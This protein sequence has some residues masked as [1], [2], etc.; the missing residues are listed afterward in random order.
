MNKNDYIENL[1][2]ISEQKYV[3][4]NKENDPDEEFGIPHRV[5]VFMESFYKTLNYEE[6][7]NQKK[8]LQMETALGV[9][10]LL[11]PGERQ[12]YVVGP[13]LTEKISLADFFSNL[14][15][16]NL[17]IEYEINMFYQSLSVFPE[18]KKEAL[19]KL[20]ELGI[21]I[22]CYEEIKQKQCIPIQMLLS[23]VRSTTRTSRTVFVLNMRSVNS[24]QHVSFPV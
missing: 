3:I 5:Y 23:S 16:N 18:E 19:K 2:M 22:D 1:L 17:P 7:L 6:V 13:Y 4:W 15:N 10:N 20:L 24:R 8:L 9:C 12:I 14:I 21:G 11:I